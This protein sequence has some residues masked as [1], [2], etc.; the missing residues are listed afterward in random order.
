MAGNHLNKGM[1]FISVDDAGLNNTIF[2]EQG[3]QM[4]LRRPIG[5]LEQGNNS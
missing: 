4:S 2:V 1:A 3:T 5:S